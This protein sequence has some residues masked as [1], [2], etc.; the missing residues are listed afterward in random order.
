MLTNISTKNIPLTEDIASEQKSNDFA[1][2]VIPDALILS[3]RCQLLRKKKGKSVSALIL[4]DSQ[5]SA[6]RLLNEITFF[7]PRLKISLFPDWEILPYE[8]FS[9]HEDLVSDRLLTLYK[10]VTG[11]LDIIVVS[12]QTAVMKL[13]PKEFLAGNTFFFKEHQKIDLEALKSQVQIA[14]YCKN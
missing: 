8:P 7:N 5:N 3:K 6:E 11:D 1:N 10:A 4:T 9:P 14:G 2:P 12:A 13:L